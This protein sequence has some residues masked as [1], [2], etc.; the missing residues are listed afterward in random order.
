MQN[1]HVESFTDGSEWSVSMLVGFTIWRTLEP[2]LKLG[3]RST[4]AN[5]NT[6]V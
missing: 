5:V 6:A 2:R 1:G 4:T 3:E